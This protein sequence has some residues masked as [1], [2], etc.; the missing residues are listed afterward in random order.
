MR[1]SA[2]LRVSLR[3]SASLRVSPRLSTC[4]AHR[5]VSQDGDGQLTKT[6]LSSLLRQC[7]PSRAPSVKKLTHEFTLADLNGD[8]GVSFD[9]FLRYHNLLKEHGASEVSPVFE[10]F[11]FFDADGSGALDRDEFLALL[12][13]AFPENVDDN[14]QL[15][16]REFRAADSDGSKGI[17]FDEFKAYHA[18]LSTLYE[19][20]NQD[21]EAADALAEA[22]ATEKA[23]AEAAAKTRAVADAAKAVSAARDPEAKARAM[24]GLKAAKA[25]A[26]AAAE[27][28]MRAAME[29]YEEEAADQEAAASA[30]AQPMVACKGCGEEFLPM[31]MPAHQRSC[32][33]CKPS[34]VT[35]PP[36]SDDPDGAARA[37]I[38]FADNDANT[39]VPCGFCSRTFF[40]DRLP[41]HHRTCKAKIAA[42]REARLGKMSPAFGGMGDRFTGEDTGHFGG[43]GDRFGP[44]GS[45]YPGMA[46]MTR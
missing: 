39:F 35:A 5:Y 25:A 18:R 17:D 46:H 6:E 41:V 27:E 20:T 7:F 21:K 31:Y 8:G 22:E 29:Q 36:S 13:Q 28:A 16:E 40:P 32:A 38:E 44:G 33:P 42:S 15:V 30:V 3:L 43:G 45:G 4:R 19:G 24:E 12:N 14:E 1:L 23:A 26:K 34:K 2:S 11:H 37:S 9:E 10:M